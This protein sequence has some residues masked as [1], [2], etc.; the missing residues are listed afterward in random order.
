MYLS[1]GKHKPA[2]SEQTLTLIIGS[3]L[4]DCFSIVLLR[5][6]RSGHEA[7]AAT[8]SFRGS[9]PSMSSF[10]LKAD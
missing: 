1:Q 5:M 4:G 8:G 2:S 3:E 7:G 9:H 10:C 6:K